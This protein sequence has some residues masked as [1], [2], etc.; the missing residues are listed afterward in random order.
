[1]N[2]QT[3]GDKTR[4]Y[5]G[6]EICMIG[7]TIL[8][9]NFDTDGKYK[10]NHRVWVTEEK[11]SNLLVVDFCHTFFKALYFDIPAVVLNSSGKGVL[12]YVSLNNEKEYPQ[13]CSLNAVIIHQ[14][15]YILPRSTFLYKHKCN[16]QD[17]FPIGTSSVPNR[18]T[19]KAE[20]S[21][22]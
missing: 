9:S 19:V 11:T 12:K 2:I 10:A 1:M 16:E 13:V 14:P 20:L 3:S 8:T 22:I 18:T 15:L 4:T 17:I 5:N 7:Y 6:S 21:F